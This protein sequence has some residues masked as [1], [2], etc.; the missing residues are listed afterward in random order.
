MNSKRNLTAPL[1][2][3]I[4]FAVLAAAD[5]IYLMLVH[6]DYITGVNTV[7]G[8]C[9]ELAEHGC[10]VTAGRF[11][12]IAGIPVASIGF[13]GAI[14]ILGCGVA[15]FRNRAREHDAF[16]SLLVVLTGFSV[17]A[18][19]T[20][21]TLSGVEGSFCPFCVA[22]YGINA[23]SFAAAWMVRNRGLAPT[24]VI[25]D[26]TRNPGFVALG[27]F[28]GAL[29]IGVFSH[30]QRLARLLEE[31]QR[32]VEEHA[33]EFAALVLDKNG[34]F[35]KPPIQNIRIMEN[36]TKLVGGATEDEADIVIV[37]FGDFQCPHCKKLWES[38]EEFLASTDRS[39][40]LHF[41]H[42]PLNSACNPGSNDLHPNAC[43][44]AV[45]GVCAQKQGK[46]WEFGSRMFETQED[47]ERADVVEYAQELGL[48]VDTF[49]T[50]LDDPL[51][52]AQV[53][54]DIA[55]GIKTELNAT[56]TFYVNG[57]S[58]T[59]AFPPVVLEEILAAI[60]A[61]DETTNSGS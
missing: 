31:Q 55:L 13:A 46:F 57:Y 3:L 17:L 21:A 6:I 40:R 42:Y 60:V 43:Q 20:M 15:A 7:A 16:R 50:C 5:G 36:P 28:A 19:L 39:I 8:A 9:H 25:D 26:V 53:K 37:E 56:P 44:A 27:L 11:G 24:D 2:A 51:S 59:G 12:A 47:L 61:H 1:L 35:E 54:Y 22:W 10:S 14:A 49:T 18:S 34:T 4:G 45:A 38:M 33:P 32:E 58:V 48:D 23:A 52:M 30:H 29:V 41:A